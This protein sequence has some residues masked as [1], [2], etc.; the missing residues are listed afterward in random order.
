MAQ[1]FPIY[2]AKEHKILN[3][4]ISKREYEIVLNMLDDFENGYIQELSDCEEE[5]VPHFNLDGI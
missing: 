3:R 5:Y 4:K 1:Y 2:K